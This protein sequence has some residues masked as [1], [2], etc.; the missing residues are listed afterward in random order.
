MAKRRVQTQAVEAEEIG[1]AIAL[2]AFK[3]LDAVVDGGFATGDFVQTKVAPAL[4]RG[5]D[6]AG[7]TLRTKVVPALGAS[8]EAFQTTVLPAVGAAL[9]AGA[10]GAGDAFGAALEA[11]RDAGVSDSALATGALVWVA[12]T[13]AGIARKATPPP[14]P[15]PPPPTPTP[16]QKAFAQLAPVFKAFEVVQG[17]PFTP[18]QSKAVEDAVRPLA[19]SAVTIYRG[20][21]S[22]VKAAPQLTKTLE[23]AYKDAPAVSSQ[24]SAQASSNLKKQAAATQ[25]AAQEA[26]QR[27]AARGGPYAQQLQAQATRAA[28]QRTAELRKQALEQTKAAQAVASQGR[29]FASN[30]ALQASKQPAFRQVQGAYATAAPR[31]SKAY[32]TAAPIIKSTAVKYAAVPAGEVYR[33]ASAELQ[34]TKSYQT[35]SK[36]PEAAVGIGAFLLASILAL[37][38]PRPAKVVAA[39]PPPVVAP[40]FTSI[41]LPPVDVSALRALDVSKVKVPDVDVSKAGAQLGDAA[42]RT[43]EDASKVLSKAAADAPLVASSAL[44]YGAEEGGKAVATA[45]SQVAG[46]A[47]KVDWVGLAS[48]ALEQTVVLLVYVPVFAYTFAA[49]LPQEEQFVLALA[50][51]VVLAALASDDE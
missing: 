15:P 40:A 8:V 3:A 17:R 37:A 26:A 51:I 22:A 7:E 34:K 6:A 44:K 23:K 21:Q 25:K 4:A 35:L 38:A 31:I 2:Q 39:P 30:A 50:A 16:A 24:L 20:T 10:A 36:K 46:E 45:A 18:L 9:A 32:A 13:G 11:A 33:K 14:P 12:L 42:K 28:E 41:K 49:T 5:G 29:V 27:A 47:S 1:D 19:D 43:G 48:S